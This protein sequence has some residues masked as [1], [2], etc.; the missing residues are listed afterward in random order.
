MWV[1]SLFIIVLICFG[2]EFMIIDMHIHEKTFSFDSFMQLEDIVEKGKSRGLDGICITD[3]ESNGLAGY[4]KKVSQELAYP[5]FVGAEILTYE[6]DVLIFGIDELPARQMHG[7]E[8]SAYVQQRGGVIISAHPYRKNNRG[9]EDTILTDIHLDGIEGFNGSTPLELN[10]KACEGALYRDL[11]VLG[12]SDAHRL[13][14]VG[15]YA[16]KFPGQIT[17]MAELVEAI[18]AGAAKPVYYERGVYREFQY[19]ALV[20]AI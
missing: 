16:T 2:S 14:R 11:P 7:P 9:M 15:R 5:I 13:D 8:L 17:C 1:C 18:K 10:L 3:H 12:G 19:E 6:G 20:D 4:A